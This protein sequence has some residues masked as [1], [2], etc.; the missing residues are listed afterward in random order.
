MIF[1]QQFHILDRLHNSNFGI[2]YR[3]INIFTTN[4][5]KIL[6]HC[7]F[8]PIIYISILNFINNLTNSQNIK[9]LS[10]KNLHKNLSFG[11]KIFCSFMAMLL[12]TVVIGLV[13]SKNI[14]S[15]NEAYIDEVNLHVA[16]LKAVMEVEIAFANVRQTSRNMIIRVIADPSEYNKQAQKMIEL[17]QV[18]NKKVN[19]LK[20]VFDNSTNANDEIVKQSIVINEEIQRKLSNYIDKN[21]IEKMIE[22]LKNGDLIK[23]VEK[24]EEMNVVA[25]SINDDIQKLYELN[26]NGVQKIVKNNTE[27]ADSSL[28]Q[29]LIIMII[30]FIMGIIF[31]SVTS[32]IFNDKMHWYEAILDAFV[33]TP[34]SVTDMNKNLTLLNKAALKVLGKTKEETIGKTCGSVWSVDICKN[35]RCGIE[36][37]KR[38]K[39]KSIFNIGDVYFTTDASYIKD[40]KGNKIGYVELVTNISSDHYKKIYNENAVEKLAVNIEKI[41]E[42][43]I[44][45]DLTLEPPNEYTQSEY[46]HF[47][48]ISSNLEQVRDSIANVLADTQGLVSA[49]NDGNI[50]F[51][52]NTEKHKGN[53]K[54]IIGGINQALE[55][56]AKPFSEMA[57]VLQ[58]M[59]TGDLTVRVIGEYKNDMKNLGNYVNNLGYS[60][61]DLISQLQDAIHTTASASAEISATAETLAVSIQE[62]SSQADEVASAM[63]QM[64]KTVT[65]NANSAMKTSNIAK[66]SGMKAND[67]G[68]IVEQTVNKM[69]QIADVVKVSA[70]NITKLGENSQKIGEIVNVINNIADQTNL[71]SLNAAIEAARAG[72]QGR[73][74]AVVADSVGKLAISTATAT[75]EIRDMIKMIQTDTEQAVTAMEKG[76]TEVQGGIELADKAGT[77]LNEILSNINEL[78]NMVNQIATASE[79]QSITSENIAKNIMKISQVTADSTR[80]VED[81][82]STANELAKMTENLTALV[83]QFKVDANYNN[84]KMLASN[85]KE[86]DINDKNINNNKKY[87][88]E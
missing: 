32:K 73:G 47:K 85:N 35:E 53:F 1:Y 9:I 52:T 10:M 21:V 24:L 49:L 13:S 71:L 46:K 58:E 3:I 76:T 40:K 72:E 28:I 11:T 59:S 70:E 41:S 56:L 61:T 16:P 88:E 63:E 74:F 34:I 51:R 66:E 29:I 12:F 25:N 68:K 50:A 39:G 57:K 19:E 27:I 6:N 83:S 64:A 18:M 86:I 43:N 81:V 26:V 23:V 87:L 17:L 79:E 60:L 31:A 69:K 55:E 80:N 36:H 82:A 42:G 62:Q 37:L 4:N 33:E 20:F 54:Q 44:D 78:L 45:I 2:E 30:A 7:Y 84:S 48:E 14:H 65:D 22:I 38:G 15:L 77:S 75:K 67:G 8:S 5:S